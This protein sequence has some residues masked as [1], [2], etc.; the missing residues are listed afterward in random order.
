M[1]HQ[2]AIAMYQRILI[3]T[4]GSSLSKKALANAIDLAA[5]T[6]AEIVAL[7]VTPRWPVSYYE[8]AVTLAHEEVARIERDGSERAQAIVEEACGDARARGVKAE[9]AVVHSDSVA[10]AIVAAAKKHGCDLIVMASHGR[11][12]LRRL[13]LGSETQHILT[14]GATPVL[15]LR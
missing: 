9:A 2:E 4:D 13:L 14:H 10:Q 3:A 12:G 5:G 7:N 6:G 1:K 11:K 15:V 8:G